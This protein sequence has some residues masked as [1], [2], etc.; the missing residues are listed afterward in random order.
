VLACSVRS[1]V[2]GFRGTVVEVRVADGVE[3]QITTQSWA[4]VER[5]AWLKG[6]RG[7]VITAAEQSSSPFQIW[8]VSYPDGALHRITNDLDSYV[9]LS[10]SQDSSKLVSVNSNRLSSLWVVPNGDAG[11]ATQLTSGVT[12]TFR[13]YVDA[14]WKTR[15]QL[16]RQ[17]QRRYLDHEPGRNQS[18]TVDHGRAC[19]S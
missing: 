17:R 18:Q 11:R 13:S 15:L 14:G 19:R 5:V 16:D 6:G 8:H 12:K 3:R 10:L 4:I 9:G 2:G 1:S 7:L